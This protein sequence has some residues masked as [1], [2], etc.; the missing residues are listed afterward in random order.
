[1]RKCGDR[2]CQ[3]YKRKTPAGNCGGTTKN[4]SLIKVALLEQ[5]SKESI[6]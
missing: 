1:L 5:S 3:L 2:V 6:L 4:T